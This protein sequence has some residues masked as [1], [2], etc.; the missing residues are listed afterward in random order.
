MEQIT[1]EKEIL[2]FVRRVIQEDPAAAA[3]AAE[4]HEKVFGYFMG[5]VM[6]LSSGRA[7]PK[8]TRRILEAEI[9]DS[10]KKE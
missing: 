10:R 9:K 4:G 8:I 7:D 1:D 5:L 6:K 3:Q 2:A